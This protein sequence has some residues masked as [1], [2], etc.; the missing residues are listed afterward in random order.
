MIGLAH[1]FTPRRIAAAVWRSQPAQWL[2]SDRYL[3]IY[4]S[5]RR[6]AEAMAEPTS[7]IR[8]NS[9]EDL[10]KFDQ[11]ERWLPRDRFLAGARKR[12]ADGEVVFTATAGGK[13]V[14]FTW[15]VPVQRESYFP[16]VDRTYTFPPGSAVMY[17]SYT[18]PDARGKGLHQCGLRA[19]IRWALTRPDINYVYGA[20]DIDN[21]ASRHCSEKIGRQP[22]EVLFRK[23]RFGRVAKGSLPPSFAR[24]YDAKHS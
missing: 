24:E 1:R 10:E 14:Y 23:C 15:L 8:V 20:I 7:T 5:D 4:R 6:E 19:M 11:S 3:V 17:N 12:I 21:R 2:W 9:I 13:L 18:H 22:H 16:F